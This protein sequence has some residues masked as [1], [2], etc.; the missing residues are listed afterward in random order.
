M[1]AGGQVH[2]AVVRGV[3]GG[4]EGQQAGVEN[5][6]VRVL[7]SGQVHVRAEQDVHLGV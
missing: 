3:A 4:G 6:V 5:I 7:R 2:Q 1:G